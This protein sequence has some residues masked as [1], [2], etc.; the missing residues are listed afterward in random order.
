MIFNKKTKKEIAVSTAKFAQIRK[1]IG[2]PGKW[3]DFK[4]KPNRENGSYRYFGDQIGDGVNYFLVDLKK[5]MD[6]KPHSW[7]ALSFSAF[8]TAMKKQ[9]TAN[10]TSIITARGHNPESLTEAFNYLKSKGIIDY[11]PKEKNI[12]TVT[13]P[14]FQ[15]RFYK[16]FTTN[17]PKGN[18]GSP[19]ARKAA[20]M[21]KILDKISST[22][23][24]KKT[25]QI[26]SPD[27]VNS[28]RF[29]L[30][31]FSDDDYRNFSKAKDVIQ[32]GLDQGKWQN[33]KITLYFTG[34]HNK[35]HKPHAIVLR[36]DQSPRKMLADEENEWRGLIQ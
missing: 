7:K 11:T 27:G 34:E 5:A 14:R 12:W 22:K 29:H 1:K 28:G 13:N 25:K 31:G 6:Q 33:I 20:I 23:L 8:Q 19:S 3:Q 36:K 21:E 2:K 9:T 18:V 35:D 16:K 15:E 4:I 32:Q 26:L 17:G 30:W 24:P 10:D